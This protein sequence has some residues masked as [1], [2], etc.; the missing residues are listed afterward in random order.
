MP[1][2]SLEGTNRVF[3]QLRLLPETQ[4]GSQRS[5]ARGHGHED[6][7]HCRSKNGYVSKAAVT[8][9]VSDNIRRL[10]FRRMYTTFR[11]I[12]IHR[13]GIL[14]TQNLQDLSYLFAI[15]ACLVRPRTVS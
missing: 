10:D 13:D 1:L 2:P 9:F 5:H 11:A 4:R 8:T 3:K 7:N 6:P 14:G 12:N 15:D